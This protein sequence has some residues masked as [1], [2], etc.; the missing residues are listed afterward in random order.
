MVTVRVFGTNNQNIIKINKCLRNVVKKCCIGTLFEEG[1]RGDFEVSI[2]Y[3]NNE[4]IH[5]IN[6]QHREIDRPT[7]VLSFPLMDENGFAENPETG[8]KMLGDIVISVEKALEQAEEFG[9]SFEREIAFLVVHSMLHL[10]GYDH[11]TSEDDE[12]EM[13]A[14]QD[15]IL[16][17]FGITRSFKL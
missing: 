3:T 14:K 4:I 5:G 17:T 15:L 16:E 10:L 13:F 12:K 8:C 7:D 11:V 2:T 9:H 1:Y 6:L